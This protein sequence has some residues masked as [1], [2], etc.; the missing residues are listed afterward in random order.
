ME[1]VLFKVALIKDGK[2]FKK[3]YNYELNKKCSR[4]EFFRGV[5]LMA[6]KNNADEFV[7]LDIVRD[8]IPGLMADIF[9]TMDFS[10]LFVLANEYVSGKEDIFWFQ[11]KFPHLK[12]SVTVR[13]YSLRNM[14]V[15]SSIQ[16]LFT[17]IRSNSNRKFLEKYGPFDWTAFNKDAKPLRSPNGRY[18]Q[19][20]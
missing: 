10:D 9:T 4:Y 18:F 17:S 14:G 11:A 1:P 15:F 6:E 20:P 2:R 16:E 19:G 7:I 3:I 5:A 13:E 12:G 8:S